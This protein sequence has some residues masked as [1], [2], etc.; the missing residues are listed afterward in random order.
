[1]THELPT[2]VDDDLVTEEI[3]D[4][5]Q[6][7]YQ[8]LN[9]YVQL[10]SASM[11]NKWDCRVYIDLFAGSGRSRIKGTTRIVSGSPLIALDI[12]PPFD[13]YIFCEKKMEKLQSLETRVRRDYSK[14]N[15]VFQPGDANE[16]VSQ[17]LDKIP[18]HRPGFKVLS[19]CFV[20]PYN[21]GDLSFDTIDRLSNRFIDFLVLIATDM[22]ASR[23]ISKYELPANTTVERF[24]G[25]SQWR[26]EWA[27]AKKNG[28]SFSSYLM[29]RFSRQMEARRYIR[30][31]IEE[32]KLVRSTEKNLPLYRLALFSRH[33]LGKKFWEQSKKYSDDQLGLSFT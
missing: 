27:A 8:L 6:E 25:V 4:W 18:K 10:F 26:S 16:F 29:D 30:A 7:K 31:P 13:Q 12:D 32:T 2:L 33:E 9:L 22:D 5:G 19:F 23:N 21:L 15:V 14:A 17:I 1:M 11:K 24:L 20:D 3:G 28:E